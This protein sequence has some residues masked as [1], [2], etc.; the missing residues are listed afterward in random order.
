MKKLLLVL[1]VV[2][3]ASFLFVGCL[4]DGIID[5]GDDDVDDDDDVVEATMTFAKEYTDSGGVT[6][7]PC[8]DTVTVTLPS[9]VETDFVVYIA[10]KYWE[11]PSGGDPG[12]YAYDEVPAIPNAD[13]TVWTLTMDISEA[14]C[15]PIC[16]VAI[17][18][19]P[20]CPGE[21]VAL[22]IVTVDC[23]PPTFDLF[24]KFTDC[25]DEC[26]VPGECDPPPF[27]GVSM[28]WTSRST[29][30]CET[31][32]CCE[33]TCSLVNGWSL[34]IEPDPCEAPCDTIP[35]TG[36]PIEGVLECAC[37]A[38]ADTGETCYYVDFSVEDNVG[39]SVTSR[40]KICLDTD[41]VTSF[42]V[43]DNYVYPFSSNRTLSLVEGWYTVYNDCA[44][45]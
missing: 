13:R 40:W 44:P 11:P 18:Q 9:S 31:I 36:C 4:G 41:E 12:F 43:D 3:M 19:H 28:E 25:E 1:M 32:D 45:Q 30:D 7:I 15:L 5:N 34:V 24:V 26:Y 29:V 16:L 33:D 20:C 17:V 10:I 39:N 35:G 23:T 6:F 38:Y 42:D 27:A 21:E 22:R 37:F 14:D 8:G 2:A